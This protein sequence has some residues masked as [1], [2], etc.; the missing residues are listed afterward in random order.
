MSRCK[1]CVFALACAM[2]LVGCVRPPAAET[3]PTP[4]SLSPTRPLPTASEQV[5]APIPT[6]TEP[7]RYR[8][9]RMDMVHDQIQA[10][11]IADEAVLE[12]MRTVPRHLFV[13][14][15]WRSQAYADHPLPIGYNQTISQ[16]FIVAWMTELLQVGPGDRVLEVG[17][18][19]GYQAAVL[20]ELGCEVY[21]VEIIEALAQTATERL[22]EMGHERVTVRHTDGYF[23]WE[24]HAPYD[25][26]IVTCA[27]DHIPSPLIAQLGEGGRMVLPVGPPGG[28]QSLFLVT[29]ENGEVRSKNL[30]G[31]RFVPLTR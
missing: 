6:P 26:I 10:R 27:P 2:V 11:G 1:L 9:A 24:E 3:P 23:G 12:A 21:T 17:T 20:G 25:A 28:Y 22:R 30:G 16:P 19:S 4:M 15:E 18:G 5:A 8:V 14:K 13:P 7:E 29:K 31:V